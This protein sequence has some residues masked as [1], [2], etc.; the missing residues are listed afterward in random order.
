[1]LSGDILYF[2]LSKQ[3]RLYCF[4]HASPMLQKHLEA[5][6]SCLKDA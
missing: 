3:R 1:M 4:I 6:L 5:R 2:T